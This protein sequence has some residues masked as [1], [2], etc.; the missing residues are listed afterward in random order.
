MARTDAIML[1]LPNVSYKQHVD[2]MAKHYSH[3]TYDNA[4]IHKDLCPL[5]QQVA[6]KHPEWKFEAG[7]AERRQDTE[8]GNPYYICTLF[9]VIEQGEALGRIGMSRNFSKGV[10]QFEITNKRIKDN[11]RR[12]DALKTIDVSK[13]V[14]LVE[15]HFSKSTTA[16]QFTDAMELASNSLE[17]VRDSLRGR[18]G[19][20]WRNNSVPIAEFITANWDNFLSTL[21]DEQRN[22]LGEFKD[23]DQEGRVVDTFYRQLNSRQV[24]RILVQGDNYI[25]VNGKGAGKET[26]ALFDHEHLPENVRRK[27][28]LLKLVED[29]KMLENVGFKVNDK[30]FLLCGENDE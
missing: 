14:K 1:T 7:S 6:L 15:K 27:L 22:R 9:Q 30:T 13:A 20:I 16:E 17:R 4:G 28:G 19:F 18:V 29:N 5:I 23:L 3:S 8:G 25:V 24:M 12:G 10:N 21:D 11:L 2:W 26:F